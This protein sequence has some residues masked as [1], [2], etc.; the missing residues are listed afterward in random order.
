MDIHSKWLI[1]SKY[2]LSSDDRTTRLN[3]V[4]TLLITFLLYHVQCHDHKRKKKQ[5]KVDD[6]SSESNVPL[7]FNHLNL[8]FMQLNFH[9]INYL[10]LYHTKSKV[11]ENYTDICLFLKMLKAC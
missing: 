9:C 6:I 4:S 7:T 11:V 3:I 5:N 1:L 10:L 2:H 8:T